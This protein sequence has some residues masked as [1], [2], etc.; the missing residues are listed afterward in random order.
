[1]CFTLGFCTSMSWRQVWMEVQGA[2]GVENGNA[3]SAPALSPES[4]LFCCGDTQDLLTFWQRRFQATQP[5]FSRRPPSQWN[6][7]YCFTNDCVGYFCEIRGFQSFIQEQPCLI[8]CP[9]YTACLLSLGFLFEPNEILGELHSSTTEDERR[10]CR[11]SW[12][13]TSGSP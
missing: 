11:S 1:M 5:G 12:V 2:A 8:V 6:L 9:V 13:L 7:P 3:S 10:N 4:W